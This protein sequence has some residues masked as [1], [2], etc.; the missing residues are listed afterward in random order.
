MRTVWIAS[1]VFLAGGVASAVARHDDT[2]LLFAAMGFMLAW[3]AETSID[4][5]MRVTRTN[6][7]AALVER[8]WKT[9]IVGQVGQWLAVLCMVG[10]FVQVF[11]RG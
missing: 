1:V 6:W 10:F 7:R 11:G 4:W 8:R 3:L 5:S 2:A 9:T